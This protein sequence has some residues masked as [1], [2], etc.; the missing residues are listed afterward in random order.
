ML[1]QVFAPSAP[2]LFLNILL[3]T[4]SSGSRVAVSYRACCGSSDALPSRA[5]DW[6]AGNAFSLAKCTKFSVLDLENVCTS[7]EGKEGCTLG[8]V[9]DIL[10][11]IQEHSPCCLSCLCPRYFRACTHFPPGAPGTC[12][13]S[14][15]M[16]LIPSSSSKSPWGR[17]ALGS[18]VTEQATLSGQKGFSDW[19]PAVGQASQGGTGILGRRNEKH[20]A[21]GQQG[22][23]AGCRGADICLHG[24]SHYAQR[25]A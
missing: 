6:G 22:V 16:R 3:F 17:L 23:A 21:R 19:L 8:T 13:P 12:G 20:R 25:A 15:D 9:R 11:R 4:A 7:Q 24:V 2:R 14:E 1:L 10:R 18:L 5:C